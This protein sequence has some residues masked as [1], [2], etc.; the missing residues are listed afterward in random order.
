VATT[1]ILTEEDLL[2][3]P[4]DGRKYEL[5][6]GEIRVSPAGARH[7]SIIMKLGGRLNSFVEE[8]RLGRIFDGQTG[9]RLPGRTPQ[10]DVRSPDVSFVV[11][12]RLAGEDLTEDFLDMA[13]DLAVEVL[14]PSD[15]RRD[16]LEK[17][18]EFLDA[19]TRLVW[20]I[21]PRQRSAAV[22]RSLTEVREIKEPALLDGEDVLPGFSCPLAEI[23]A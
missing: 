1:R 5:V 4:K 12:G 6:D 8:R 17:V 13:P 11:A 7:G 14:S 21:D 19:G 10:K 18:G 3:V 2:R 15:R 20:V 16:I 23:L 9:F 22:Y